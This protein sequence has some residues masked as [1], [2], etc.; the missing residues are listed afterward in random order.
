[1]NYILSLTQRRKGAKIFLASSHASRYNGGN[2]PSG[3]PFGFASRLRRETLLQRWSHQ[4]PGRGKPA[5]STGSPQRAGLSLRELFI[6]KI[7]N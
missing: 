1:M 2:P 6:S 5:Y 4:L 3:S 7:K